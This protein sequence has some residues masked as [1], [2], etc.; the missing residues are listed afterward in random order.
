MKRVLIFAFIIATILLFLYFGSSDR[1]YTP[2]WVKDIKAKIDPEKCSPDNCDS[3]DPGK[4]YEH[5]EECK[6]MKTMYSCGPSCD[7]GL[8]Y[9]VSVNST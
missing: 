9:C 4:C 1:H 8:K 5:K 7:A 3:C 6:V 2:A